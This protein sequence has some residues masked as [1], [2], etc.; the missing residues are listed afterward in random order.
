MNKN[1]KTSGLTE[2]AMITGILVILAYMSS[3][4]SIVTFFYPL[5]AVLLAKR[6]G[7]KYSAMSL[8]AADILVSILLGFQTGVVFFIL[9][10]P[11]SLSFIYC[12]LKNMNAEKTVLV[13]STIY[14]ISFVLLILL[15][16]IFLNINFVQTLVETINESIDITKDMVLTMNTQRNNQQLDEVLLNMDNMKEVMSNN[17]KLLLPTFVILASV[18]VSFTNYFVVSKLSRRFSI[19]INQIKDFGHISLPRTFFLS[20]AALLL[21]S[22]LFVFLKVNI[23][24]V[25]YNLFMIT[26][27]GM[28]IQGFAVLKFFL[29]K[30]RTNKIFRILIMI[31]VFIYPIF[32]E[33][34]VLLGMID[35]IFD[36]RRIRNNVV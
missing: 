6:K 33:I 1:F 21:I 12:I 13:S 14:M 35:L 27:I 22:Y 20:M 4:F 24:A 10:T 8:L 36:L 29:N 23:S 32:S 25:Q 17:L 30:L 15:M 2:A 7:F 5:P 3:F 31:C 26:I 9:Y 16:Q 18:A 19:E 34:L 11:L 28:F